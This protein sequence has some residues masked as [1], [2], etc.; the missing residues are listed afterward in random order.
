MPTLVILAPL[1]LT[2]PLPVG[3]KFIEL[4]APAPAVNVKTPVPVIEP[5]AVP[6]PPE[7]TGS[8]FVKESELIIA[9]FTT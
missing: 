1:T 5:V 9:L 3:T 2:T 4:L 8:G 7:V 6:V